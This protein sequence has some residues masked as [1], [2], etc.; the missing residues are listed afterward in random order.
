MSSHIRPCLTRLASCPLSLQI[1]DE[2]KKEDSAPAAAKAKLG[3][4]LSARINGFLNNSN[5]KKTDEHAKAADE[6]RA[7]ESKTEEPAAAVAAEQP[8]EAA[9]KAPEVA[10]VTPAKD[11]EKAAETAVPA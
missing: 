7:E 6:T 11:E 10:P 9:G 4:R 5:K 3:R 8:V 2:A 1:S